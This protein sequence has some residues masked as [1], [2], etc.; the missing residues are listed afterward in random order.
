MKERGK[1]RK[2]TERVERGC[3]TIIANT[4]N[5]RERGEERGES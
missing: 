3:N 5:E 2:L 1:K 4:K